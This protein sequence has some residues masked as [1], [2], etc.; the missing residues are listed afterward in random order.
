MK[1]FHVRANPSPFEQSLIQRNKTTDRENTDWQENIWTDEWVSGSVVGN[2][3]YFIFVKSRKKPFPRMAM[4][5]FVQLKKSTRMHVTTQNTKVAHVRKLCIELYRNKRMKKACQ[6]LKLSCLF[7]RLVKSRQQEIPISV[8]FICKQCILH[9]I[10]FK[11]YPPGSVSYATMSYMRFYCI[12]LRR[13]E[14]EI[15]R[16]SSSPL[17]NLVAFWKSVNIL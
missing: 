8:Q 9:Q 13:F 11:A 1:E 12:V 10:L 14:L 5:S 7:K 17:W 6:S 16:L 4:T 15:K 3:F 2:N